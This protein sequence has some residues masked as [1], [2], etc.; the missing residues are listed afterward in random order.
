[1]RVGQVVTQKAFSTMFGQARRIALLCGVAACLQSAAF[2]VQS[3]TLVWDP[4][5]SA[6]VNGYN[7]Y[8]GSASGSYTN[9]V[10]ASNVTNATVS[11]LL[12]GA[13][14]Y[15]AATAYD[16][17]GLESDP[18]NEVSYSVPTGAVNGR[19]TLDPISDV[20]INE[21]AAPQIVNL[22]GI[23]S[24]VTN[25]IQSLTVS[26]A[27]SNPN[28]IP[29][30]TVNY[31][32]PNT[33]GSLTFTPV[34]NTFGAAIITVTVNN[35]QAQSNSVTRSFSVVTSALKTGLNLTLITNGNGKILPNLGRQ[36]LI[37]GKFYT[38]T[39]VP[40]AGQEFAGW[41]GSTNWPAQRLTFVMASNLVLEASFVPSPFIPASGPYS[42]LF[43]EDDQVR[44]YSAGLFTALVTAHGIYSGRIQL[45]PY[46]YS[47]SGRLD[48]Q[49]QATNIISRRNGNPL[50]I[51][52]RIGRGD[53][54]DQIFGRLTDG[55][56]DSTLSGDRSVFNARTN[57]APYAGSYT[58]CF[59]G[60][61]SD[62]SLPNGDGFGCVRVSL[63]GVARLAGTLSDGT[64]ISEAAPLSR[65]GMWP[66]Y[67]PLYSGQGSLMSWLAFT[68]RPSDDLSGAVSWIKPAQSLARYYPRGFT[69]ECNVIGS[70][71]LAPVGPTNNVL[72][73]TNASVTFSGGDLMSGFTNF[74]TIGLNSQ[75]L[76]LSGDR[77]TMSFSR[78]QGTFLG[79]TTDPSSGKSLS[80]KGAVLQK[81]N[82]G[83]GFLMGTNRSS[84]VVIGP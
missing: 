51:E 28:L 42:G 41:S 24:G 48:L 84:R 11:G 44:Q 76:K 62:A 9:K 34:A 32:S 47:F 18:S 53:Q 12:E 78:S 8:Y 63:A 14:Y 57:P 38:L 58:L 29:N 33:T 37:A 22:S 5:T 56:W 10:I 55:V 35:G 15:F 59:P 61:D 75:V 79:N 17:S 72:N 66:L 82:V 20:T 52:L 4:S 39:A 45:G 26:A 27:S 54:A 7:I 16:S 1:L 46:R 80:F 13:T 19:P 68:N 30:P 70:L 81:L 6:A 3:I 40:A 50:Q 83:Y 77:L 60:Q 36:R 74:V 67:V 43:H 69:N 23:T 73:L 71:Y 64:K 65:H 2:A 25:G 21:N 49:C 31:T